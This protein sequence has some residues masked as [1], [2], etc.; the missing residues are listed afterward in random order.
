V[1]RGVD[2]K[3]ILFKINVEEIKSAVSES[4]NDKSENTKL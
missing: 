2:Q 4:S 3:S 1:K